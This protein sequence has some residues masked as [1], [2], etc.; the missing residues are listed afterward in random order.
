[1][2]APTNPQIEIA[3]L[4]GQLWQKSNDSVIP[5]S[6][7]AIFASKFGG[8]PVR[9]EYNAKGLDEESSFEDVA[10]EAFWFAG[11]AFSFESVDAE[12]IEK[13][14]KEAL[15]HAIK[16]GQDESLSIAIGAAA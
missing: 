9:V 11:R 4:K 16:Q 15:A 10:L 2:N 3:T 8:N 5:E 7:C 1:M 14:Q 12:L 13:W 6:G